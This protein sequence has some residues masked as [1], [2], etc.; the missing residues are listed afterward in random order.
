MF[1]ETKNII[2]LH[3]HPWNGNKSPCEC[4]CHSIKIIDIETSQKYDKIKRKNCLG[5]FETSCT[6]F[7]INRKITFEFQI[8]M[9]IKKRT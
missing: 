5:F 2:N 1:F 7:L 6:I 3:S 4:Q 8:N 9:A